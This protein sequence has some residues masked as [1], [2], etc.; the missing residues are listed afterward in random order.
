MAYAE[1]ITFTDGLSIVLLSSLLTG[2]DNA[3]RLPYLTEMLRIA[4]SVLMYV[5]TNKE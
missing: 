2:K 3:Y 1:F 4:T 5:D